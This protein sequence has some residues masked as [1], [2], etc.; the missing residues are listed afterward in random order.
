MYLRGGV[1]DV[2]S[3]ICKFVSPSISVP[4]S[5]NSWHAFLR[6]R[7]VWNKPL[8][9]RYSLRSRFLSAANLFRL[10]ITSSS[11]FAASSL[12]RDNNVE[13]QLRRSTGN[14]VFLSWDVQQEDVYLHRISERFPQV[15]GFIFWRKKLHL[16][17][18]WLLKHAWHWCV[19]IK[20]D[21]FFYMFWPKMSFLF[22][23]MIGH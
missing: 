11:L 23:R 7:Y 6:R 19:N 3:S 16:S 22:E 14:K 10:A 13:T 18:Y 8:K 12:S 5:L 1:S 4:V 17:W 9:S 2:L 21:M 20:L 15:V